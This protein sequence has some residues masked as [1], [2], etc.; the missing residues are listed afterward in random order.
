MNPNEAETETHEGEKIILQNV[1]ENTLCLQGWKV[2]NMTTGE[3]YTFG[4][5][6]PRLWRKT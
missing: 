6:T 5:N 1:T 4:E 3:S 2:E